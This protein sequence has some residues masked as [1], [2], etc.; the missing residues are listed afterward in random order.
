MD[1]LVEALLSIRE[2]I[3]QVEN[4]SL[5]K[6]LNPLKMAPHTLE[7]VTSDNWNMPYSREL[8]AFPKPW[9]THKAW[10]TVGRVDDQYGDRNLVCTCPPI[11]SYQ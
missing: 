9:C 2:E 4:G 5:D 3:R 7:K 11:E 8:A 1:R 6:H 10:P